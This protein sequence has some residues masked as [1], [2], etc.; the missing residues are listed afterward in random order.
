MHMHI[1][2][3]LRLKSYVHQR[4]LVPDKPLLI[5]LH[6]V[7][8]EQSACA[9]VLS[10]PPVVVREFLHGGLA[11]CVNERQGRMTYHIYYLGVLG[12][13]QLIVLGGLVIIE[14]GCNRAV[15]AE[16]RGS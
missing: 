5:Q 3:F 8:R 13:A 1:T 7:R 9:V 10:K 16:A 12:K 15:G 2:L 11:Q 14:S 6:V 4:L